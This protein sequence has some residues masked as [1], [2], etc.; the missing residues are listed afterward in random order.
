VE[1][2]CVRVVSSIDRVAYVKQNFREFLKDENYP[3]QFP[4]KSKVYSFVQQFC[5]HFSL[6]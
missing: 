6:E 5:L 4:Y 3:S 1:G 2:L